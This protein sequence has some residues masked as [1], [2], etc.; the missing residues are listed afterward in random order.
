MLANQIILERERTRQKL[1][2]E[3]QL[4]L[5][6]SGA[7]LALLA[8][9]SIIKIQQD[10]TEAERDTMLYQID[11]LK[12]CVAVRAI[13]QTGTPEEPKLNKAKIETYLGSV[14][15]TTAWNILNIIFEN[16]AVSNR[17]I[18]NQLYLSSKGVNNLLRRMYMSFE[19]QSASSKNLKVALMAKAVKISLGEAIAN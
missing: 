2:T 12:E 13:C 11:L 18:A 8:F 19:V 17:T 4:Y 5:L 7:F 16:P 10:R 14:L 1:Q 15:G 9:M 6:G 3:K